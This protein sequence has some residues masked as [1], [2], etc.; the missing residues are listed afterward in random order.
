M[1]EAFQVQIKTHEVIL[2]DTGS[3]R[4]TGNTF[5]SIPECYIVS[6]SDDYTLWLEKGNNPS[7]FPY[8]GYLKDYWSIYGKITALMDDTIPRDYE[9]H[10]MV[11][12]I[13]MSTTFEFGLKSLYENSAGR[14]LSMLSYQSH[15]DRF[16]TESFRRYVDFIL[17]RPWYEFTYEKERNIMN[18]MRDNEEN[19]ARKIR[20]FERYLLYLGEFSIKS[21]YA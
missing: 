14:I 2:T 13:G 8:W 1:R 3:S 19:I 20:G 10:T 21:I 18:S 6:I 15:I 7:D 5:M 11:R 4:R 16:Y 17:L 12:V 9:Y